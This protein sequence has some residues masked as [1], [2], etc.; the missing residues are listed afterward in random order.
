MN[1]HHVESLSIV[2]L[3]LASVAW[4]QA[5]VAPKSLDERLAAEPALKAEVRSFNG[6]PTLFVNDA[7]S[8]LMIYAV[9]GAVDRNLKQI[10]GIRRTGIHYYCLP[11]NFYECLA[12]DG[13]VNF[14][15]VEDGMRM[16]LN[17]DPDGYVILRLYMAS[18]GWWLEK[19]PQE[20]I[21]YVRSSLVNTPGELGN[22]SVASK[23]WQDD[24]SAL[25]TKYIQYAE[26]LPVSKRIVGYQLAWGVTGEWHY[27]EFGRIPDAGEAMTAAYRHWLG[28]TYGD[29]PEFRTIAV[30]DEAQRFTAGD[31]IFRD[32]S[33]ESDR[34]VI[35]YVKC[36]HETLRDALLR[37][38][39]DAKSACGRNKLVG[40][41]YGYYFHMGYQVN[42]HA[43]GG[44]LC[45]DDVVRSKDIDF[46]AGPPSYQHESRKVGGECVL[47]SLTETVTMHGKLWLGEADEPT[48]LGCSQGVDLVARGTNTPEGSIAAMQRNFCNTA[49]HGTYLWW[50]DIG[51]KDAQGGFGGGWWAPPALA[52]E[53]TKLHALGAEMLHRDRSSVAEVLVICNPKTNFN[54][55]S[56]Y[57]GK[58]P[59]THPLV[60]DTV[61]ALYR[62]GVAF[63]LISIADLKNIDHDRYKLYVFLDA[64]Y[65]SDADRQT[66]ESCVK[67]KNHTVLW[68]YAPGYVRDDKL[69]L[70]A[71]SDVIGMPMK[72]LDGDR[73]I[74]IITTPIDEKIAKREARRF[75]SLA[76]PAQAFGINATVRPA[77]AV[78]DDAGQKAVSLGKIEGTAESGLAVRAF[79]TWTSI[80]TFAPPIS[81]SW[82]RS[83]AKLAGVHLYSRD[84]DVMYINAGYVAM[85]TESGGM[86][87]IRLPKSAN[88]IDCW[89]GK[90]VATNQR[91]LRF[92]MAPRSTR[93]FRIDT[94]TP[95]S[96]ST[97]P[98]AVP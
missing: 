68:V 63:D 80:Y 73:P 93:L 88:I 72:K 13:S 55:V 66:I 22:E 14:S 30:P 89:T 46:L 41:F 97:A 2:W 98:K 85:T 50:F 39:S 4:G 43:E 77:F 25:L 8:E 33:V 5:E 7:P 96:V 49:L 84:N 32:P 17:Y 10:D 38:C 57:S 53:M 45:L 6:A 59:L 70:Q 19:Y 67:T 34:R 74:K 12:P 92:L 42:E 78:S 15:A 86:R 40:A 23:V 71:M 58:D 62:S 64:F 94:P 47:R 76:V 35:D 26:S 21:R 87:T 56:G 48:Y 27:P 18:P 95:T 9:I 65:M 28:R 16:L 81:P 51:P 60:D 24:T 44:H 36:Q 91:V 90:T 52:A 3:M 29:R 79:D 61:R 1:K 69:S 31:G 11:V 37:F 54:L 75:A 82:L 83:V 20:R